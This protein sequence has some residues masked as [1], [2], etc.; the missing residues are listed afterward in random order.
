M[1]LLIALAIAVV[2]AQNCYQ[3][4]AIASSDPVASKTSGLQATTTIGSLDVHLDWDDVDGATEYWVRWREAGPGNSLNDGVRVE[5]SSADITVA[6]FGE[7]V[8]RVESCDS[9]GCGSQQSTRFNVE[10]DPEATPT[11]GPVPTPEPETTVPT[12]PTELQVE[13]EVGSLDVTADWDDV[14]GATGYLVRWREAGPGNTLN[15][16]INVEFSTADLTV[17]DFG[18]WVVRVEACNSAGCGEHLAARFQVEPDPEATPTPAPVPTPEPRSSVPAQPTELQV[19]TEVGSLDVS[20]DWDDVDGA[21]EYW[22]RWR[23]VDSGERLN[24]GVK[25]ASSNADITV[26]DYG[27]WVMRLQAC[28]SAGCS[29]PAADQFKVEVEPSSGPSPDPTPSPGPTPSPTPAPIPTPEPEPSVPARPTG[30]EVATTAGSLT[31]SLD[32]EDADG[33]T[34]YWVSW[35]V[36][37]PGNVLNDGVMVASSTTEIT[38]G[39]YGDWV[40]RVEACNSAGCGEHLAKRFRVEPDPE[41]TPTPTPTPEPTPSPT[42]EPEVNV[43]AQPTGLQADTQLGSLDV[44]VDWDDVPRSDRIPGALAGGWPGQRA[45]RRRDRRVVQHRHHG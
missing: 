4:S 44:S 17:A 36:A 12:Q 5:S 16:G 10:P 41:A 8:A 23:S 24:E 33:A 1:A 22:V 11:P 37:G 28:N 15:D 45:Q 35:R 18:E 43:P 30:L 14:D 40:V 20:V 34:E 19:E 3:S 31:V 38:L 6:D 2:S 9:E 32:W 21:T 13:T 29:Q 7:W 42:P 39:D 25:V 26:G 27:D